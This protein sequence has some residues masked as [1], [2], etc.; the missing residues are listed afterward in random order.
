MIYITTDTSLIAM[1]AWDFPI[2]EL[3]YL[4]A[5]H[6]GETFVLVGDRLWETDEEVR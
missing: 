2:D 3:D 1:D 6:K 5:E 4:L